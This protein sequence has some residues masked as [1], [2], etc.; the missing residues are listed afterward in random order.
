MQNE[1]ETEHPELEIALLAVNGVGAESGV[2]GM[3]E[4]RD[5]PLLQDTAAQDAWGAW[6]V[7]YRDVV[8]LDRDNRVFGV[9]NLTEHDLANETHYATLKQMLVDAAQ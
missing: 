2:D 4:G 5:I 6:A 8:V 3:S 1:I 7:T 9:F